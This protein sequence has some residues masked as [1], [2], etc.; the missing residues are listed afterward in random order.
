MKDNLASKQMKPVERSSYVNSNEKKISEG[1]SKIIENHDEFRYRY[2]DPKSSYRTE[3]IKKLTE[4]YRESL[5]KKITNHPDETNKSIP[6][7]TN[8]V[9]V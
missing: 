3:F 1:K 9:K 8:I 7:P 4:Q 5:L 6:L 2:S